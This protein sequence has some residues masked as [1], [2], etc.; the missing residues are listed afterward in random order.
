VHGFPPRARWG[1]ELYTYHLS[2]ELV[3]RGHRV[4]VFHPALTRE[5]PEGELRRAALDGIERI[6]LA[7]G[8]LPR[9][10]R[11][12]WDPSLDAPFAALLREVRFD[13]VHVQHLVG[14]SASLVQVARQAGIPVAL[15]LDDLFFTCASYH[16][17]T[18]DHRYCEPG[19]D[20]LERCF[21]CRFGAWTERD[22][23]EVAAGFAE[24]AGRRAV[25]RRVLAQA[26]FV[27]CASAFLQRDLERFGFQARRLA[28]IRTGIAPFEREA[29]RP[30]P[31]AR[32][33]IGFLG[34]VHRRKGIHVF[35]DAIDRLRARRPHAPLAFSVHASS[36]GD[37][38]LDRAVAD[39]ARRGLLRDAGGFEPG[40]RGALFAGLDLAVM[41]SLGENYPFAV[42]EAIFAGVPVAA[43]RIAAVPEIVR[44]GRDGW[45]LPPGD[46]GA[47]AA[48]FEQLADDPRRLGALAP[49]SDSVRLLEEEVDE[50][51]P[52][53]LS[54]AGAASEPRPPAP[55]APASSALARRLF[56]RTLARA[57]RDAP[58]DAE[59]AR[60]FA[61]VS[62]RP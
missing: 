42:R 13:L 54:L 61:L 17:V 10:A 8:E 44:E 37:R 62:S 40:D 9:G 6:E 57:Q 45:L 35:L 24:L 33:R 55:P 4:T 5:R 20:S 39:A 23:Q 2:R 46:A 32:L 31:D 30:S 14:L 15:K 60:L 25:L 21:A 7:R 36:S 27:Q 1:T 47:L 3:R 48:L 41:P 50:L 59:L 12:F 18:S 38:V 19:P 34:A 43:S 28:V 49:A 16:R 51:E 56:E 11:E 29:R 52:I 26:D 53:L 22:P 58:A